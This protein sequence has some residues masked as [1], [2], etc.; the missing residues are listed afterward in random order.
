VLDFYEH[1]NE[2]KCHV[3]GGT[4]IDQLRN[5]QLLNKYFVAWSL[6]I[7]TKE[8]QF[9]TCTFH[10]LLFCTVTKKCT[11]ISQISQTYMFRQY[12]VILR[13]LVINTLPSYTSISKAAVGITNCIT[14]SCICWS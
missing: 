9:N 8:R 4:Y 11:I 2:L 14:N 6:S 12:R 13:K 7:V 3:K 1:S 10:L 5:Y